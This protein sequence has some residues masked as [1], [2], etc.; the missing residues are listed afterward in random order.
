MNII[1]PQQ[2][3]LTTFL[4]KLR[5][6][7]TLILMLVKVL[8]WNRLLAVGTYHGLINTVPPVLLDVF[9]I[10]MCSAVLTNFTGVFILHVLLDVVDVYHL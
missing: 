1:L 5:P 9:S 3:R 6:R 2:Y 4:T 7:A 8:H 10:D